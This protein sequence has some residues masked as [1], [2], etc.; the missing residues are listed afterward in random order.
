[1]EAISKVEISGKEVKW[2][3]E[4]HGEIENKN[5]ELDKFVFKVSHDLRGLVSSLIGL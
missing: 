2:Q 4:I 1:M 5:T 3:K